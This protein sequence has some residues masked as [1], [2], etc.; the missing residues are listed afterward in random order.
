MDVAEA[1]LGVNEGRE[2]GVNVGG[3][4]EVKV[5]DRVNVGVIADWIMKIGMLPHNTNTKRTKIIIKMRRM[6]IL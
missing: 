6:D 5:G 4:V 3:I 2:V 1:K